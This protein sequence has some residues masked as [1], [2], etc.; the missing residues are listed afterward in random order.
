M[1]RTNDIFQAVT[2]RIIAGLEQGVI[3]WQNPLREGYPMLPT[4]LVSGKPYSGSNALLLSMNDYEIPFYATFNQI[5]N[6]GGRVK[7]GEVSTEIIFW[8]I[9][10]AHKETR[11]A[12]SQ[13]DYL[14]LTKEQKSNYQVRPYGRFYSVFNVEQCEGLEIPKPM[15]KLPLNQKMELCEQVVVGY[16]KKPDIHFKPGVACY[17]PSL[18]EVRMPELNAYK[19]S[20]SFYATLFHELGHSTGHYSRLNRPGVTGPI[21]FGSQKYSVEE[22][23]AEI[24]ASFL[25]ANCQ[26]ENKVIDNSVA[27]LNSWISKLSNDKYMI[28]KASSEAQKAFNLIVNGGS[29]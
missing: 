21:E 18:D 6:L 1:K 8:D 3:P 28:V 14:A 12:I 24:T 11:E 25:C 9:R 5:K 23:I 2:D 13:D 4:N 29:L 10:V 7:E 20:E 19:D 22:L 26:I 16:Q 15:R 27:Y 17:I